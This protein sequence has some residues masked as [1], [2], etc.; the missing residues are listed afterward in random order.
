M[1]H[2]AINSTHYLTTKELDRLLFLYA[3]TASQ[4]RYLGEWICEHFGW[5][6]PKL[7]FTKN[8]SEAERI[9]RTEYV[10]DCS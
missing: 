3:F 10:N 8:N 1:E 4:D 2:Y 6:H 9:L 5:G 7:V